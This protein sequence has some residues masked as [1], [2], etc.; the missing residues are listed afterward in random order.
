M[1]TTDR[2]FAA[3]DPDVLLQAAKRVEGYCDAVDL[4]LLVP[5]LAF[6]FISWFFLLLMV[7]S[8]HR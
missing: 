7:I 4:N 1:G 6:R 5:P 2:Q 3:N 8:L